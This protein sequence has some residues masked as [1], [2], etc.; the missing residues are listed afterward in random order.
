MKIMFLL[1]YIQYCYLPIT[2]SVACCHKL[3]QA[4]WIT[5]CLTF[6]TLKDLAMTLETVLTKAETKAGG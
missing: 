2:M 3:L 4:L 5:V 1:H 6:L